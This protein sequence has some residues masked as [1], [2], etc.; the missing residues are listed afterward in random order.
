MIKITVSW[1]EFRDSMTATEYDKRRSFVWTFMSIISSFV[2]LILIATF[3]GSINGFLKHE[4]NISDFFL[5]F[6]YLLIGGIIVHFV[7]VVYPNRTEYNLKLIY[8]DLYKNIIPEYE[9]TVRQVIKEDNRNLRK[10]TFKYYLFLIL[11]VVLIA[12]VC[13]SIYFIN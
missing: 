8:L 2:C 4:I 3:W 5:S 11:L 12:M 7:Y 1:R 9:T 10:I 6:L 13:L